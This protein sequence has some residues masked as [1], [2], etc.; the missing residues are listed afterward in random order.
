MIKRKSKKIIAFET[1]Y[2][3]LPDVPLTADKEQ[4]IKFGHPEIARI[5][6]HLILKANPP[7]TIGLF[8]KWGTGKTTIINLVKS[9]LKE[10]NIN[11][12]I[13]DVWK[14]E[15]DSLRRQ[16]L[17]TI[18]EEL[19][20]QGLNLNKNYKKT[21]NQS[22]VKPYDLPILE[23]LKILW[24]SLLIKILG[25]ILVLLITGLLIVN[26]LKQDINP[27]VSFIT[28]LSVITLFLGF[29]LESFRVVFGTV[30]YHKTDSAEGFES[31]FYDEI[32]PKIKD[33]FLIAIDNLD[34][35]THARAAQLLS[36]I[37]TFLS[38]DNDTNN[39][40]IFLIACDEEAIKKHLERSKFDDPAEFLRKFFNTSVKIPRFLGEELDQ[41]T[42]DLL[43]ETNIEEFRNNY[44]LEWLITY[45]FRDN[46][47]EIKQFINTLIS[48]YL[49]AMQ[50]EETDQIKTKGVITKKIENLA[51]L[52]IISQKFP[53]AYNEIEKMALR[54]LLIWQ[55]IE[56]Y[57]EAVFSGIFASNDKEAKVNENEKN[58]FVKFV[59]DTHQIDIT[60]LS[61][62]VRLRQ[63]EQE[64]NLPGLEEYL[65]AAESR[66]NDD[67]KNIFS[68]FPRDKTR[69]FD[70]ILKEYIQKAKAA[71]KLPKIW[72]LGA[73][74]IKVAG[75]SL[76]YLKSFLRELALNF[77]S[78]SNLL[79]YI[80]DYSPKTVFK[81]VFPLLS[82]RYQREIAQSYLSLF[83]LGTDKGRS[84]IPEKYALE[85][86]EV[87]AKHK[88]VFLKHK[89]II[90]EAVKNYF[91]TEQFLI[92]L[93][94]YNLEK[95]FIN[96]EAK[97]QF[98]ESIKNEDLND[99]ETISKNLKLL[100]KLNLEKVSYI[101]IKKINDLILFET[102]QGMRIEQRLIL[103]NLLKRFLGQK[104]I[105]E[106]MG[107][108]QNKPII[109][110]ISD[111][112][113]RWYDQ[114]T[115]PDNR[116]LYVRVMRILKEIEG[117]RQIPNIEDRIRNFISN[118]ISLDI[119]DG[120]SKSELNYFVDFYSQELRIA[121]ISRI[122]E[123][124]DK[125][126]T[127]LPQEIV[128]Q[129]IIDFIRNRPQIV[130]GK[131]KFINYRVGN[132]VNIV[133]TMLSMIPNLETSLQDQYFESIAKMKCGNDASQIERFYKI[134]LGLKG[135]RPE[136]VKRYSRRRFFNQAQKK[137][138]RENL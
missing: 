77:P 79:K 31:I 51:K 110:T 119:I 62:L 11:T 5:V 72:V 102:Q 49:L 85:L 105:K 52:L 33:K 129:V 78:S 83:D 117:N 76:K 35:T 116:L 71:N 48:H 27:L 123:I 34:R 131:L 9:Y 40:S 80:E 112:I 19:K 95:E 18:E 26:V 122:P 97:G 50:M 37:K 125:I 53:N 114:D 109:E 88:D 22:L 59:R 136:I 91:Y 25:I 127:L 135:Q 46:P 55:E 63:S 28:N 90:R 115:N 101:V 65:V 96:D 100:L 2:N 60:D 106:A 56:E 133:S 111:S 82:K 74:T 42:R 21:L 67:A 107:S 93:V 121:A 137:A 32:L 23:M 86:I 98:I 104:P 57:P 75:D 99:I 14:Y 92:I 16:F 58:N 103:V 3:L 41:Y 54:Q 47:R 84:P 130:P 38:K 108:P 66:R 44:E 81:T 20:K 126:H 132:S 70:D 73:T 89:K 120:L 118:T 68:K 12:I 7:F 45:T 138:L 61:I 69:D 6:A 113:I 30:Q 124:F 39:K 29:V 17:I 94:K 4:D 13:F 15:A 128:D 10:H 8:G 134:L 64:Q 24:K 36:D 1:N 87:F 43:N